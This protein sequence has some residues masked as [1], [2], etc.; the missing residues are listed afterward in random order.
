MV[1]AVLSGA[2]L[3][4][5][6]QKVQNA[7]Q[8][9]SELQLSISMEKETI[10]VLSAEWDYLNRPERLEELSDKYLNVQPVLTEQVLTDTNLLPDQ[11]FPIVPQLKPR[12]PSKEYTQAISYPEDIKNSKDPPDKT[13]ISS[14]PKPPSKPKTSQNSQKKFQ[15]LLNSLNNNTGDLNDR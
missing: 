3:F 4:M 9:V 6:S 5:V 1:F 15:N 14:Y 12:G 7:E 13:L 2:S 10:R 8:D 11:S